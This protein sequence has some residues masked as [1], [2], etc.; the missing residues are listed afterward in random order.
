[1]GSGELEMR[2]YTTIGKEYVKSIYGNYMVSR[3]SLES[4]EISE[5]DLNHIYDEMI[6][7]IS[8]IKHISNK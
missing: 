1:M 6:K 7:M 2:D 5:E 8:G 3:L 4:N